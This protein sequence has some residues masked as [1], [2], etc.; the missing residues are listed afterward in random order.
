ME[1]PNFAA[2]DLPK[3]PACPIAKKP[4]NLVG[5]AET[6]G[7][8]QSASGAVQSM[9]MGLL[10]VACDTNSEVNSAMSFSPQS[11]TCGGGFVG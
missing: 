4:K 2:A 8:M 11:P 9:D 7:S 5:A 10:P 1:D 3:D 6:E